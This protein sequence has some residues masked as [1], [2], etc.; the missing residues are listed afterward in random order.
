MYL[1]KGH[2]LEAMDNRGLASESYRQALQ[3]DVHCFEAYESLVQHQMLSASEGIFS[4]VKNDYLITVTI[5]FC[6]FLEQELLDSLPISSQCTKEEAV[7]LR[8]LYESRLKKYHTTERTKDVPVDI[9]LTAHEMFVPFTAITPI[10]SF[11]N[12][13]S[14]PL[15]NT[16]WNEGKIEEAPIVNKLQDSLDVVVS[17]AE[18]FYYNCEYHKCKQITEEVLKKDPYHSD[19]LPVH[20]ASLVELKESQSKFKEI[21]IKINF[22]YL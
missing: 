4:I 21:G 1:L 3:H 13:A 11:V 15:D 6:Y 17:T 8:F 14:T 7:V 20:I 10:S 5:F 2:L 16:N 19:C 18:R 9:K 22:N 12:T